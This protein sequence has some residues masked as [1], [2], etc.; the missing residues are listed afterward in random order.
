[1]PPIHAVQ[2]LPFSPSAITPAHQTTN[3]FV[4]RKFL[5]SALQQ[6]LHI[7]PDGRMYVSAAHTTRDID[8]TLTR[9]E[10]VFSELQ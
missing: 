8:E 10:A 7:V 5:H 1:M 9:L 3:R 6:G 4:L 2:L